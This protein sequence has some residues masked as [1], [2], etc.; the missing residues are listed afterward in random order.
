[1]NI[2]KKIW[3]NLVSEMIFYGL[4]KIT[5]EKFFY[6]PSGCLML[7]PRRAKLRDL[8]CYACCKKSWYTEL[9]KKCISINLP[10]DLAL[11]TVAMSGLVLLFCNTRFSPTFREG[12]AIQ[13]ILTKHLVSSDFLTDMTSFRLSLVQ[14]FS[15]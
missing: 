3:R 13:S 9:C 10:L 12:T 15:W 5:R 11:N 8:N 4:C 2:N 1:M 6:L 14:I 7:N